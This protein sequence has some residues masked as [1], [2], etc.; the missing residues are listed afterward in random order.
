[1]TEI[2]KPIKY[3]EGLYEVSNF[4]RIRKGERLKAQNKNNSGY[5]LVTLYKNNIKHIY[6]VHRLVAETFISNPNN[7]P[8]VNHKDEN[9]E[10]NR[11]DNLE[12]CTRK[13]NINYGTCIER[14]T[15]SNGKK[16]IQRDKNGNI[17][18]EYDSIIGAARIT[19]VSNGNIG[20]CL[21][22]RR[23]TAGGYLWEYGT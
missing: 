22:D 6:L 10:N 14:I 8:C 23:K 20:D 9:K 13:Y 7:H 5:F 2:W 21:H 16:I 17:V 1:M 19:G 18:G 11:V 4:G 3:Y 15:K 12:W